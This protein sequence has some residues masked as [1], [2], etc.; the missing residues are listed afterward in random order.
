MRKGPNWKKKFPLNPETSHLNKASKSSKSCKALRG[1]N[2][3]AFIPRELGNQGA[4]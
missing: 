4:G 1:G 2:E 3:T